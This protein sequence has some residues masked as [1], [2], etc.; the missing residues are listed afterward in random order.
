VCLKKFLDHGMKKCAKIGNQ[1]FLC[2]D[3]QTLILDDHGST[4]PYP[5][6]V[7]LAGKVLDFSHDPN[8]NLLRVFTTDGDAITLSNDT[9]SAPTVFSFSSPF[10]A[11]S[12][13][14][15][16]ILAISMTYV[17]SLLNFEGDVLEEYPAIRKP[18]RFC[19]LSGAVKALA[20][21]TVLYTQKYTSTEWTRDKTRDFYIKALIDVNR[22]LEFGL[23][24]TRGTRIV[25]NAYQT[26]FRDWA[27]E[28]VSLIQ[29]PCSR[30]FYAHLDKSGNL[31][32]G[33]SEA[34]LTLGEPDWHR[35]LLGLGCSVV[36]KCRW[37]VGPRNS[38]FPRRNLRHADCKYGGYGA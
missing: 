17:P 13:H 3:G 33:D 18:V 26:V 30:H 14:N 29:C 31:R 5:F 1:R 20:D 11:A 4:G 23:V 35:H 38:G 9:D 2:L 16:E 36:A 22:H 25:R 6:S 21:S 37:R 8:L 24:T 7:D 15:T 12:I 10:I 32:V 19:F 28:T 34:D 27:K